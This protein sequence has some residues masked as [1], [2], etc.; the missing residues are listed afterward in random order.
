MKKYD[1]VNDSK[2]KEAIREMMSNQVNHA[3]IA[4]TLDVNVSIIDNVIKRYR[5]KDG[6]IVNDKSKDVIITK[7]GKVSRAELY[8]EVFEAIN[9]V[10][11]R[12]SCRLL[13]VKCLVDYSNNKNTFGQSDFVIINI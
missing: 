9:P 2:T 5:L 1:W 7:E 12:Y 11:E 6:L 3:D 8:E 10:I 13:P 4:K